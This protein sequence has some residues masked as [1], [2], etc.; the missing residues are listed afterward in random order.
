MSAYHDQIC[1]IAECFGDNIDISR[2]KDGV[3]NVP[4]R[5]AQVG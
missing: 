4:V 3:F 2:I 5:L 1:A